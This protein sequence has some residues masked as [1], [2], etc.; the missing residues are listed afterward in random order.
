MSADV[1]ANGRFDDEILFALLDGRSYASVAA[2]VGCSKRTVE[3]RM[4]DPDF[5]AGVIEAAAAA[6][7]ERRAARIDRLALAEERADDT[8]IDL[9]DAPAPSV[10]LKAA[11]LIKEFLARDH[12]TDD[13]LLAKVAR[14]EAWREEVVGP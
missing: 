14:L 13:E 9:L 11:S 1:G 3:R 6:R 5:R 10:R 2:E 12:D 7:V 4:A 8:L